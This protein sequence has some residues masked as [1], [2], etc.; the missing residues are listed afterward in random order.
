M[1]PPAQIN[2]FKLSF[3]QYRDILKKSKKDLI[4]TLALDINLGGLYSEEICH[5]LNIQKN[6][7]VST[8]DEETIK[9]IFDEIRNLLDVFL[10]KKF[11][12]IAVK[13]NEDTID[14]L[15]I[16]LT[17]L[18]DKEYIEIENFILNLQE[19]IGVS[20]KDIEQTSKNEEKIEKLQRQLERQK[21]SVKEFQEKIL[22]KKIEGDVIYLNFSIVQD[23]LNQISDVLK[24]KQKDEGIGI[25]NNSKIVKNFD[26]TSNELTVLLNDENRN[27][28]TVDLDFRKTVSENAELAYNKSKKFQEKLR[29]AKEAIEN[30]K[31]EIEKTRQEKQY[32][33]KKPIQE[34]K[35][36]WFESYRWF[37][38]TEGNV[39]V[40]GKDAKTNDIVVKK[41]LDQ[42]DRYVHADVHGAPSCIVKSKN[43]FGKDIPITEK[44]LEEACI[45]AS[46]FSKAWNQYGEA[47]AYWVLP[48]QVSK[49]PQSGEFLPKGAFVIRGKRNYNRC[50]L[51][52][53]IGKISIDNIE[54]ITC[55]PVDSIA[56]Q[57]KIYIIIEPGGIKKST[58]ANKLS[59]IFNTSVDT[60]LKI[61][62]PGNIRIA[63]TVGIELK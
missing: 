13:E 31:N 12:P 6:I 17:I 11:T 15:P 9:K 40:A 53:A 62:P 33:D 7:K 60:I 57:S 8:L 30:T 29:G 58:F 16:K 37:I 26:P 22:Q 4:R 52:L 51:E 49:T 25:I 10:N 32:D 21:E 41:Y 61:L 44:T 54:K 5:R 43:I 35:H 47:N 27:I 46:S 14:V 42:G 48:E 55:G 1:P 45:F 59:K 56:S 20:K 50:K 24:Q 34:T 3:K 19:L 18:L 39:I 36:F 2:P 23:I 28:F 63:K 38:S